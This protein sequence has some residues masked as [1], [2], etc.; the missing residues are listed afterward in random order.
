M[1]IGAAGGRAGAPIDSAT[2]RILC[3]DALMKRI[4][5]AVGLL[6]LLWP[7]SAR[8]E[9]Y[10]A[11]VITMIVPFAAGGASDVI[12]RLI[13]EEMSQALGQRIVIENVVGAGG[14]TAMTRAARSAPDGYTIVIGN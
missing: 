8:S 9:D 1:A 3:G 7:P 5:F 11:R 4:R 12:A 6:L 14:A 10:P 2:I 13:G